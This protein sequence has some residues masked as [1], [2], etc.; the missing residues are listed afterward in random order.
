MLLKSIAARLSAWRTRRFDPE[1]DA[2]LVAYGARLARLYEKT[3]PPCPCCDAFGHVDALAVA[4][5]PG[6]AKTRE[7]VLSACTGCAGELDLDALP[8]RR[9][10]ELASADRP[11]E[12]VPVAVLEVEPVASEPTSEEPYRYVS[13]RRA[14]RRAAR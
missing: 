5:R 13:P 10:A 4:Y 2:L 12:R 7:H 11:L 8:V 1:S 9:A 14:S 3:P 6:K